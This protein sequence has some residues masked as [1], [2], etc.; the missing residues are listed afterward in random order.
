MSVTGLTAFAPGVPL[1]L[2]L[3]HSDGTTDVCTLNHTFNENQIGWFKAGS[4]LNL[5]AQGTSRIRVREQKAG[6]ARKPKKGTVKK[7]KATTAKKS[8]AK[9]SKKSVG[10]LAKKGKAKS[11]KKAPAKRATRANASAATKTPKR[12][13]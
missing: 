1:T 5:I 10:K 3:R 13:K 8:K 2:V 4:A 9:T 11:T 6:K 12:R 7:G